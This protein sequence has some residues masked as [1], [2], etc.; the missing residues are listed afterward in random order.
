MIVKKHFTCIA[1]V[2]LMLTACSGSR[3]TSRKYTGGHYI[4]HA[5]KPGSPEKNAS[6]KNAAQAV[7]TASKAKE[8]VMPR[9]AT[10]LSEEQLKTSPAVHSEKKAR[11]QNTAKLTLKPSAAM[12][13]VLAKKLAPKAKDL[14]KKSSSGSGGIESHALTGF[15]FGVA[16][17]V[18]DIIGFIATVATLNYACL[19]ILIPALVLG[20][21]GLINGL[22][23]LK[24]HRHSKGSST[25]LVFSIVGTACGGVA[26]ILALYFAI[27][28]TIFIAASNAIGSGI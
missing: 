19:L 2:A 16:G 13:M 28:G 12:Q 11:R 27:Y 20:I 9:P 1:A 3:F 10:P 26:I 14:E 17:L 24:E 5:H 6:E 23:G 15:I 7:V 21:L 8:I 25:D 18:L 22:K 4:S